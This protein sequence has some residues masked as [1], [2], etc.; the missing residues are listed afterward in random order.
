MGTVFAAEDQESG[1][2]VAIKV[3]RTE[4]P[5]DDA[6]VKRF[7]REARAAGAIDNAHVATVFSQGQLEDGTPYLV[8]ELLEGDA[9][10]AVIRRDAPLP[11]EEA[12]QYVL[13]ACEGVAAAHAR[14]I[15][16]RDLKPSNLFRTTVDG[17]V[18]VKV[19]DFGI[20]KASE[21]LDPHSDTT[22]LTQTGSV[23]GSPQYMSPEQLRDARE[24]DA[25]TDIWAL[26]LI[27]F[28]LLARR[29]AF[30]AA[31]VGEHFAKILSDR[32]TPLRRLRKDAPVELEKAIAICLSKQPE[33]RFGDVGQLAAA[34]APFGP[35]G[36]H[37]RAARIAAMLEQAGMAAHERSADGAT[38]EQLGTTTSPV[39]D[40]ETTTAGWSPSTQ[41][42][43]SGTRRLA[44]VAVGVVTISA[45]TWL[46]L[47]GETDVAASVEP[48]SMSPAS[49]SAVAVSPPSAAPTESRVD[50]P[51]PPSTNSASSARQV[52]PAA[53]GRPRTPAP[54]SRPAPSPSVDPPFKVKGPLESTL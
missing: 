54:V 41:R 51:R 42:P 13:M 32:P 7:M 9:L 47:R 48:T 40:A 17:E 29:A 49:Q 6:A 53:S 21:R 20:S 22:S 44:L 45:I 12:V 19:L 38:L 34:L 50:P 3:M 11:I 25:R 37:E 28:K 16:H 36:S 4:S 24:V 35:S 31:T 46:S 33:K 15:I 27:L 10:D 39:H 18:L 43:G 2:R 26:G 23:L 8:L 14:G 30:E 1:E 52:P 5:S